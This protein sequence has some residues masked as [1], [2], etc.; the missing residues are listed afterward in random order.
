[1]TQNDVGISDNKI[2][3]KKMEND[4]IKLI[5]TNKLRVNYSKLL[6]SLFVVVCF[7]KHIALCIRIQ[8]YNISFD[9]G[10]LSLGIDFHYRRKNIDHKGINIILKL[11]F[12]EIEI[13]CTDNRHLEDYET[14]SK[15]NY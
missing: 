5:K 13:E 3:R 6:R 7:T 8:P 14:R 15:R 4:V 10:N 12:F 2:K 11:L 9:S 1:M